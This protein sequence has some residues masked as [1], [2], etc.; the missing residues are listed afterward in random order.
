VVLPPIKKLLAGIDR[1]D[2][3]AL[4]VTQ[5]PKLSRRDLFPRQH[6]QTPEL[7]D[8]QLRVNHRMQG[9]AD[10]AIAAPTRVLVQRRPPA[11]QSTHNPSDRARRHG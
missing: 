10:D 3:D 8:R 5:K 6:R 9:N 11:I 4:R 1:R 7:D 2:K